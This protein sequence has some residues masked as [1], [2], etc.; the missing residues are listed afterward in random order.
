MFVQRSG[1]IETVG[2]SSRSWGTEGQGG[3]PEDQSTG[4][5]MKEKTLYTVHK[6]LL[7]KRVRLRTNMFKPLSPRFPDKE[8]QVRRYKH[9]YINRNFL[10]YPE[11]T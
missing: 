4:L 11:D 2:Q 8:S 5:N 6:R 3:R 7:R 10:K 1:V 9:S